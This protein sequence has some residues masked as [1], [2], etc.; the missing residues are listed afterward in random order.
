[1]AA[2]ITSGQEMPV[3]VQVQVPLFA[4]VLSFDRNLEERAGPELVI[5]V[6]YQGRYR[7]SLLAKETIAAAL[8]EDDVKT[9]L[10]MNVRVVEI[11]IEG[12][13]NLRST[14]AAA[15]VRLLYLTPLRAVDIEAICTI[16]R[17]MKITSFTGVPD[18]VDEGV[19]LGIGVSDER[20]QIVINLPAALDEGADFS[21]QLLRVAKVIR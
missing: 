14:I 2:G 5:G 19:A 4:K 12:D 20:P 11:N 15:G 3:P 7:Q 1:M 6:L 8:R 16:S 18:Y 10:H 17:E 21:S 9:I 13:Q